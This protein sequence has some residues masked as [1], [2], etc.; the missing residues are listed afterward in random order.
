MSSPIVSFDGISYMV[1][2]FRP[3]TTGALKEEK[4]VFGDHSLS[5]CKAHKEE[6][7]GRTLAPQIKGD[8]A[9]DGFFYYLYAQPHDVGA[10]VF[11]WLQ[12]KMEARALQKAIDMAEEEAHGTEM[13]EMDKQPCTFC[14]EPTR[15]CGGD[16]SFEMRML[17]REASE[18]D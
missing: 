3:D 6:F 17:I 10:P 7:L 4:Y 13:V 12:N 2:L 15:D 11:T 8:A 9:A 5:V 1:S 16:H 14:G 18:K